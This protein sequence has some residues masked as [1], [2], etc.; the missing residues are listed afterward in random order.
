MKV[1]PFITKHQKNG[2]PGH[3]VLRAFSLVEIMVIV[4]IIGIIAGLA[5][6]S[7]QK[8]RAMAFRSQCASNLHAISIGLYA[9]SNDHNGMFPYSLDSAG[10]P[11]DRTLVEG[12]YLGNKQ[13]FKCPA[14]VLPRQPSGALAKTYCLNTYVFWSTNPTFQN[15]ASTSQGNHFRISKPLSQ[16]ILLF[17]RATPLL[18]YGS[19]A[20][21]AQGSLGT[22]IDPNNTHLVGGN[23]LFADGHIE[24]LNYKTGPLASVAANTAR[25]NALYFPD[26]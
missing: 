2:Q 22:N 9:Y 10:V 8:A 16:V 7:L 1:E 13:I 4:A 3:P 26:H 25:F 15:P 21:S 24:F 5:F 12:Q 18:I 20:S 11:L 14:D 17:E 23:F 6:G 19:P